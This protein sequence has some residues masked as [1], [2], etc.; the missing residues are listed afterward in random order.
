MRA[1]RFF[2]PEVVQ[3]SAMDCGPAALAAL[4]EGFG[5]HVAY[6]RLREACQTDVDGTSID[7]LEDVALALGLEVEQVVIPIDHAL[8][9]E[10]AALPA[11]AAVTLPSGATHFVVLWRTFGPWVQVMNP[12]SG[13]VW[14]RRGSLLSQLYVHGMLAPA[15]AWREWAAGPEFVGVLRARLRDLGCRGG[16]IDEQIVIAL[17]DASWDSLARLDAAARM[18]ADMIAIDALRRGAEVEGA[19]VTL[20]AESRGD[21]EWIPERCWSA[22][23]LPPEAAGEAEALG[24]EGVIVGGAVLLRVLGVRGDRRP[25]ALA[26]GEGEDGSDDAGDEVDDERPA[27]PPS[28]EGAADEEAPRPGRELWRMIAADGLLRPGLVVAALLSASVGLLLEAALLRG[29][30]ELSARLGLPRERMVA[31]AALLLFAFVLLLLEA[32]IVGELRRLG[33]RLEIRLRAA[34]LSKVPRLGAR[35]FQSRL[36]SDMAERIHAMHGLRALPALG[37][38]IVRT[39]ATLLLTVAGVAWLDPSAALIAGAGA[40]LLIA[41]AALALPVLRERDL[42]LRSHAGALS[43]VYLDALLGLWP[44]RAHGAARAVRREHEQLLVEWMRAGALLLRA[45]VSV[46]LIQA[47]VGTAAVIVVVAQH[48]LAAGEVGAT[49]LL[50][51]WSMQL[52]TLGQK[53]GVLLRQYPAHRSRALRLFEPLGAPDEE[54]LGGAAD[55]GAPGLAGRGAVELR[56]EGVAVVAG[57]HVLLRGVTLEVAAGEHV[58]IVGAS[59]AGKST[60]LGALLG[61][62]RPARGRLLVDGAPLEGRRL[63]ELRQR[64]AWID[65]SVALWNEALVDNLLYGQATG[66][67]DEIGDALSDA[68]LLGLVANLP[69]GLQTELGEGGAVLS[70]GEGQRVRLGRALLRQDVGLVLLDEALRGLDH[71]RRA[72][73]LRRLRARWAGATLLCATHDIAETLE[74]PRVIVVDGGRVVEDGDP[75]ELADRSGHYA[76]MLAT[77]RAVQRSMW[78]RPEWRRVHL[79]D[80]GLAADDG[81]TQEVA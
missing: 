55:P 76:R 14:M 43:R 78:G 69:D 18:L 67:L 47:I 23:A 5:I 12:S 4:L 53:V 3:S 24:E 71:G 61:W 80:G 38:Q 79:A 37:G 2:A 58:A 13:R 45:S 7:R 31:W 64:T 9:D 20:I 41:V 22:R 81:P 17:A 15:S 27:L 60:L 36:S 62:H 26:A 21:G 48:T 44:I 77:E 1:P 11:L 50:I 49:L 75:R 16:F 66:A 30:V 29:L 25:G 72:A 54:N 10:A 35:Y 57:G 56:F 74:F 73:L 34:F 28:L 65:P 70:G 59:G 63:A 32:T 42:R 33:R 40:L 19:L 39:T 8:R 46:E 68:D 6:G 51:Y 52:P